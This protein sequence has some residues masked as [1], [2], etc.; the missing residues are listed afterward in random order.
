MIALLWR[1]VI[2]V[3]VYHA[4]AVRRCGVDALEIHTDRLFYHSEV[5]SSQNVMFDLRRATEDKINYSSCIRMAFL[6]FGAN[7]VQL[8]FSL[9]S[10]NEITRQF[11]HGIT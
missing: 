2:R 8:N 5:D 11:L 10:V 6:G 9:L 7:T 3:G 4:G 1:D